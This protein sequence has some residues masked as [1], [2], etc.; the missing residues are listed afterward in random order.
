MMQTHLYLHYGQENQ[1]N[2]LLID[3]GQR[4][5]VQCGDW[6]GLARDLENFGAHQLVTTLVLAGFHANFVTSDINAQQLKYAKGAM[7]YAFEDQLS[8]NIEDV[9]IVKQPKHSRSQVAAWIVSKSLLEATSIRLVELNCLLRHCFIDTDLLD[10]SLGLTVMASDADT[11]LVSGGSL[12]LHISPMWLNTLPNQH[13]NLRLLVPKGY[14][15][16]K[17]L[18]AQLFTQNETPSEIVY[19]EGHWLSQLVDYLFQPTHRATDIWEGMQFQRPDNRRSKKTLLQGVFVAA[20]ACLAYIGQLYYVEKTES[21][22]SQAYFEANMA[23]CQDIFGPE[24]RCAEAFVEREVAA[25]LVQ[26]DI[27]I[28]QQMGLTNA[29]NDIALVMPSSLEMTEFRY[30][31]SRSELLIT[32]KANNFQQLEL[33]RNQLLEQDYDVVLSASQ[34]PN[35]YLGNMRIQLVGGES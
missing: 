30:D 23:L 2:W 16:A 9:I 17:L 32:V 24:K 31:Q 18:A 3:G 25:L 27:A 19:Y 4:Q 34:Q 1:L 28:Q 26:N 22:Q 21:A 15:G 13:Q 33:L 20:F 11:L 10:S 29:L 5:T 7:E 6:E 14:E 35:S 12:R 8:E